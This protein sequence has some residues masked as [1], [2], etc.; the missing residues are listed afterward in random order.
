MNALVSVDNA[1]WLLYAAE[2]DYHTF[3]DML[4][5]QYRRRFRI[6]TKR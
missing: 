4:P 5:A 2:N 3:E 1:A 6:K